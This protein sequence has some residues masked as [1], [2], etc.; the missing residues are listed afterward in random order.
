MISILPTLPFVGSLIDERGNA[1]SAFVCKSA[2]L[3]VTANHGM[4][5][6]PGNLLWTHFSSGETRHLK[7]CVYLDR[8]DDSDV[9][10]LGLVSPLIAARFVPQE[11][12]L[13]LYQPNIEARFY[14]LV[15][16]LEDGQRTYQPDPGVAVILGPRAG[17]P[18]TMKLK[19]SDVTQGCSGAPLIVDTVGGPM[20]VGMIKGLYRDQTGEAH[21]SWAVQP[22]ALRRSL[23]R[24]IRKRA[25]SEPVRVPSSFLEQIGIPADDGDAFV[26]V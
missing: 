22:G 2:T 18:F 14:A 4:P 11:P 12:P 20:V 24:A 7:D 6:V 8:D 1:R 3:L 13:S 17:N 10:V 9:A 23:N 16:Y 25:E 19:S 15:E 5:E 21:V 26:E